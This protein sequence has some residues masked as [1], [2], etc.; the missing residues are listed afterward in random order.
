MGRNLKTTK[1]LDCVLIGVC[2]V[3]ELNTVCFR[4]EMRKNSFLI[5]PLIWSYVNPI[6]KTSLN[7]GY[8]TLLKNTN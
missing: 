5:L 3:I 8:K 6:S 7:T 4:R 2:A 1:L